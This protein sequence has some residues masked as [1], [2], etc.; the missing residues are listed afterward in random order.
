MGI[1][2]FITVAAM[3]VLVSTARLAVAAEID[4]QEMHETDAMFARGAMFDEGF[5]ARL[6][7]SSLHEDR[8]G[9]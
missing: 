1:Y 7:V 2:R 8:L 9:T 4:P 3:L 5:G 6:L